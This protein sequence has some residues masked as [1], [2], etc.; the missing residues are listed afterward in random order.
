IEMKER[1][2]LTGSSVTQGQIS[3]QRF[4]RQY[5]ALCGMTGTAQ[6]SENELREA[7]GL[8]MV[9][10]PTRLP[11]KRK[12]L[13]DRYFVNRDAKWQAPPAA[14]LDLQ[15]TGRPVLVGSRTIQASEAI[16]QM[17]TQQGVACQVL[18][19]KQSADEAALVAKAGQSGMVTVA[20]NM[21]G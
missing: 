18:N 6:G 9:T 16:A 3:R 19:G 1:L 8:S 4:L 15:R 11:P 7:Y 10:I 2:S 17:L 21:A 20:T 13:P 5:S 14:I 12:P